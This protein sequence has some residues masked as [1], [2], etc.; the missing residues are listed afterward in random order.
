MSPLNSYKHILLLLPFLLISHFVTLSNSQIPGFPG[1]CNADDIKTLLRIKN[2]LGNPPS[3]NS[4]D[5]ANEC[6]VQ[7]DGWDAV[8]CNDDGRVISLSFFWNEDIYKIP[9]FLDQLPALVGLTFFSVPNLTGPIPRYIGKLTNLTSLTFSTTNLSGPIPT[10]LSRLV[11]LA[12][13]NLYDNKFSG[14]VPNFLGRLKGLTFL[15]LSNNKLTGPIPK[16]LGHLTRLETLALHT[17]SLSGPIPDFLGQRLSNLDGLVLYNNQFSGRIPTSLG[18]LTRLTYISL[19]NNQLTGPVPR[20][21]AGGSIAIFRLGNNKL[22]G[23][24]TFLIDKSNDGVIEVDISNNQFKFDLTNV[25]LAPR[26]FTFNISHNNIY[27]R[28]PK[29]FYRLKEYFEKYVDITYNELCGPIPNGRHL[30]R[31][32]PIF[33]GHNKC[34]CGGPLP[35]CK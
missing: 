23:D 16:S 6:C 4:W 28:L 32:N 34:L 30:K 25:D 13:L 26:L 10:F 24:A 2:H 12:N 7:W 33:F 8:Q 19:F 27:G 14:A 11:K 9:S 15:S 18:L 3:L 29:L 17:N 21:L 22:T 1:M 35:V 20:S 31:V 5:I